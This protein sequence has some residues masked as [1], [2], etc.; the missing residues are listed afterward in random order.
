MSSSLGLWRSRVILNLNVS[1]PCKTPC[2]RFRLIHAKLIGDV[3]SFFDRYT[4]SIR[5][6]IQDV[7]IHKVN[8]IG[9]TMVKLLN[10][11]KAGKFA[12]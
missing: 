11:Q 12:G 7:N 5:L 10:R 8:G 4:P 3:L 2:F 6:P 9:G 1:I